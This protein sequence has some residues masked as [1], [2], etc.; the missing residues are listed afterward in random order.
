M[1]EKSE[2]QIVIEA[3]DK[4]TK[5]LEAVRKAVLDL[6]N[7]AK[8]ASSFIEEMGTSAVT[9]GMNFRNLTTAI[10]LGNI[11]ATAATKAVE[12][13]IKA[14]REFNSLIGESVETAA[15][16]EA[17]M[18]GLDATARA[19]GFDVDEVREASER[20]TRDGLLAPAEAA[21]A[22]KN[23]LAGLAGV[24]LEQAE[25]LVM[26]MK[27]TAA[28]NRV[29]E[30]Y[31]DAVVWTTKGIR[32]RMSVTSDSAGVQKNLMLIL[33]E[34]GF[35]LQDLDDNE[36]KLA[37]TQVLINGYLQESAF[38]A[39]NAAEYAATYK[40]KVVLLNRELEETKRSIGE[41]IIPAFETLKRV[42]LEALRA[43]KQWIDEHGEQ[44][45]RAGQQLGLMVLRAKEAISG[46]INAFRG[47]S[48][49]AGIAVTAFGVAKAAAVT[50]A[51]I[52][53]RT[54]IPTIVALIAKFKALAANA[55]A[56]GTAML[57][58]LG[59]VGWAAIGLAAG[60]TILGIKNDFLGMTTSL[61]NAWGSFT[62]MFDI[63][64]DDISSEIPGL[65]DE[66]SNWLDSIK[67]GTEGI[68]EGAKKAAKY[69]KD[70]NR[71]LEDL[72]IA[73]REAWKDIKEQIADEKKSYQDYMKERSRNFEKSM[74]DMAESHEKKTKSIL[75]D[76][77]DERKAAQEQIDD[78]SEEWNALME[79]TTNA[80]QDRLANLQ[81][82]L[83]K[84]LALGDNADQDKILA[85]QELIKRENLALEEALKNQEDA[86][87]EEIG[88]V[89]DTLNEKI[90]EL[91]AELDEEN[92]LYE[93]DV[94][95]KKQAY[96]EDLAN[97]KE[98]H[99]RK[100]EDL[101]EK[102]EEEER[103]RRLYAEDFKRIGDKMAE[104]DITRLKR[105]YQEK[106]SELEGY[107][108]SVLRQQETV[109]EQSKA[110]LGKQLQEQLDMYKTYYS[111]IGSIS[112]GRQPTG[113]VLDKYL[114]PVWRQGLQHGGVATQPSIVGEKG[115]P[116]V[117][118]PL[119]EPSRMVSILKSLGIS[120][121]G[122]GKTIEQH[123][124]IVV[125]NQSDVDMIMERAAFN[126]KYK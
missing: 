114:F 111:S 107:S 113:T 93:R 61:K 100:L 97:Y 43:I 58:G 35:T 4:A 17:T 64:M 38:A 46:I 37:A 28:Y 65:T 75:D 50:Y 14:V 87:N 125:N 5:D 124:H 83:D 95:E 15:E 77:A 66:V 117:V 94:Q 73:H 20:L 49:A 76:I 104:D 33:K 52:S 3:I 71:S 13:L 1:N 18:K 96:E 103:I 82:Q 39:G 89:E 70:Y 115:Y 34:H 44:L 80:G 40:G 88:I 86:K 108:N 81:A 102:L 11:A 24:T 112:S 9:T 23:L 60:G 92:R 79:L 63:S 119:S 26:A 12:L 56:A 45:K 101:E 99:R 123:F 25:H 21:A 59:P 90:L 118:L 29:L 110:I 106:L 67:E 69:L 98:S 84:E 31:G 53:S 6:G 78:I 121:G 109:A 122:A 32:N 54:L 105:T 30:D 8:K 2:L 36:K 42:Q 68:S 72:V 19:Y 41:S 10:G 55:I 16:Y 126:M 48:T 7:S 27:D 51:L 85:L 91:E 57:V 74:R 120:G 116:E 22:L 62:N 47:L